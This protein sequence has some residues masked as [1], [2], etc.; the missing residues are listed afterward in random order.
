MY[1]QLIADGAA[2]SGEM[3]YTCIT[4]HVMEGHVITVDVITK[5]HSA[6]ISITGTGS[7]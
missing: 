6:T 3:L 4:V 2:S 7:R 1:Q 5:L